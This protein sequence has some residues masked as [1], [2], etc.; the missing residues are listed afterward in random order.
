MAWKELSADAWRGFRTPDF[1]GNSWQV[2]RETLYARAEGDPIDLI[3]RDRYRNFEL[4]LEWALPPGGN[5]GVMY[6]V[7]EDWA[8]TWQSGPEMQLVDDQHHP[9]GQKPETSCGALYDLLGPEQSLNSAGNSFHSARLIVRDS[10]VEHWLNG[11]RVLAYDLSDP[12]LITRI[13]R[14]KFRDCPQFGRLHQGHIVLQHHSTEAWFR[15]IRIQE[16]PS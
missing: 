7:S 4:T 12:K 6:R 16:L 8:E 1:P 5:S 3:S 2:E 10:Q 9:D 15:N 14:S 11:A 13:A